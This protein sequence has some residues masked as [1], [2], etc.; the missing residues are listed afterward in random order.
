MVD[1]GRL[2]DGTTEVRR[3]VEEFLLQFGPIPGETVEEQLRFAY[4]DAGHIDSVTLVLMITELEEALHVRLDAHAMQSEEFRTVGG[5]IRI[6]E[7]LELT[8]ERGDPAR[9]S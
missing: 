6:F 5:L 8:A 1:D 7:D 4:L 3:R 2:R 9:P